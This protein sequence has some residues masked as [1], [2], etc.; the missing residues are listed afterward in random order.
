M[1]EA[2]VTADKKNAY[3]IRI[4][5]SQAVFKQLLV[6]Q[7]DAILKDT[8]VG[9]FDRPLLSCISNIATSAIM[10]DPRLNVVLRKGQS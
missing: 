3:K 1:S 8:P 6:K 2:K 4:V 10:N 9:R 5:I 7:G